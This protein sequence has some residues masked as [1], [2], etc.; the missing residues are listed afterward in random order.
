MGPLPI[1]ELLLINRQLKLE[2]ISMGPSIIFFF[3]LEKKTF[4]LK[5]PYNFPIHQDT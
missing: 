2:I 3:V 5:T 4:P 1:L